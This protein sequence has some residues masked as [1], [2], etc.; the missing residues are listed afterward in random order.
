MRVSNRD[1][2]SFRP[3]F[4][5]TESALFPQFAIL[6]STFVGL[7]AVN[8]LAYAL[9]ADRLRNKIAQ[10]SVLAVL[11]RIGGGA[12]ITMGVVT[13]AFRRSAV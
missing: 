2:N 4:I 12:L 3:P 13:A 5:T 7:A 10:Q 1:T 11:S 9:L 8:A 6:I